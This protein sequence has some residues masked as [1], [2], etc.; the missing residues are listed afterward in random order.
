MFSFFTKSSNNSSSPVF[1]AG[2]SIPTEILEQIFIHLP[3]ENY[4][5]LKSV[6]R[7]WKNTIEES[8]RCMDKVAIVVN[9]SNRE[10][11][12]K[13]FDSTRKCRNVRFQDASSFDDKIDRYLMKDRWQYVSFKDTVFSNPLSLRNTLKMCSSTVTELNFDAVNITNIMV[14]TTL[15]I[16]NLKK[17]TIKRCGFEVAVKIL[18][19]T[20]INTTV[21]DLC[22]HFEPSTHL[23]DREIRELVDEFNKFENLE[24][25]SC[26]VNFVDRV[27]KNSETCNFKF[28]LKNLELFEYGKVCGFVYVNADSFSHFLKSQTSLESYSI[29]FSLS[30]RKFQPLSYEFKSTRENA[31]QIADGGVKNIESLTFVYCQGHPRNFYL[32]SMLNLGRIEMTRFDNNR[33]TFHLTG[34]ELC[35]PSGMKFLKCDDVR[36][37]HR[38]YRSICMTQYKSKKFFLKDFIWNSLKALVEFLFPKL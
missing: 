9:K 5:K 30:S 36:G 13:D 35:H 8:P 25:L 38:H 27:F 1:T 10:W 22:V 21:N 14:W 16:E 19:R 11:F 23:Y 24:K 2:N 15:R 12:E 3:S 26:G 29:T 31:D 18:A 6:S 28:K 20:S 4:E 32:C 33:S 37:A 17:M 7:V 34:E